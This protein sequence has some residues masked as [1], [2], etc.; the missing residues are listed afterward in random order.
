MRHALSTRDLRALFVGH[1]RAK[2]KSASCT[3]SDMKFVP[4]ILHVVVTFALLVPFGASAQTDEDSHVPFGLTCD[5]VQFEGEEHDLV[6]DLD[7]GLGD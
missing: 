1:E 7:L 5:V 2:E 4:D 3:F 6:F